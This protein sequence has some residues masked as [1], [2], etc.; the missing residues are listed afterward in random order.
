VSEPVTQLP[1]PPDKTRDWTQGS[2]IK[3]LLR[4]SWPMVVTEG[5]GV[6][7]LTIDMVWVGRL[8]S[9]ALAGV[10]VASMI[11]ILVMSAKVGLMTGLRAMVAR[12]VGAGDIAGATHV[13]RQAFII[14]LVYSAVFTTIGLIY[15]RPILEL[16]D[17]EPE[18]ID[19]GSNYL[20]VLLAGLIGFSFRITTDTIMQASGDTV[21]PMVITMITRSM[22]LVAA[23]FLTFGWWIFPEMGV[24]GTALA[25]VSAHTLAGL[26]GL[27]VLFTGRSRLRLTASGFRFDPTVVVRMIRIG[28]PSLVMTVQRSIGYSVLTFLLAPFGTLAIAAYSLTQRIDTFLFLPSWA[29]STGGGVLVG[30][31]LGAK[32]PQRSVK[33]A[34][35]S[36]GFVELLMIT[37]MTIILFQ[38][39]GVISLFNTEPELLSVGGRFL[40]LVAISY[41]FLA[42][43]IVLGQSISGAGDTMPPM[44][45]S[46]VSIWLVQI[47]LSYYLPRFT[48]ME[49]DGF[50]AAIIGGAAVGA[51]I[52]L[53]YF[54]TGRWMKKKL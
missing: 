7:A 41:P 28:F 47:P 16:F 46:I 42:L 49:I 44:L 4:L 33:S 54:R 39:E 3:N 48:G 17:L 30:Q 18:V 31:N 53:I 8:G 20:R 26:L 34:W 2:I 13:A 14:S 35:L 15:S 45:I 29:L 43:N 11:I 9:T 32:K 52:F 38:S 5:I 19:T 51:I 36:T 23:P 27:T 12:Y 10:G 24:A 40:F 22:H 6:T 1:L 21:R 25:N 37:G 50:P